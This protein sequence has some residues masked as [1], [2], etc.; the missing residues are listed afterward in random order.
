FLRD[1]QKGTTTLV[2]LGQ[3]GKQG[4]DLSYGCQITDDGKT[5]VFSSFAS[6]L[7]PNDTNNTVDVFSRNLVT[8]AVK[9]VSVTST[10][11]QSDGS[12]VV[13]DMT[14]NGRYVVVQSIADNLLPGD[15]NGAL[16]LYVYDRT[17]GTIQRASISSTGAEGP[18]ESTF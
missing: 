12:S 13:D 14:P 4:N 5:L 10:G 1:R 7:V 8:G 17:A 11:G 9:R 15:T 16:D 2:S 18:N 6:N 3:G